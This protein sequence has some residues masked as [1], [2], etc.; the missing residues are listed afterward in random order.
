VGGWKGGVGL[1]RR[2][3]C[4]TFTLCMGPDSESIKLVDGPK[5]KSCRE[6]ASEKRTSDTKSFPGYFLDEAISHCLLRVFLVH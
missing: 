1:R 6:G 3:Y 2:P 5:T 4:R